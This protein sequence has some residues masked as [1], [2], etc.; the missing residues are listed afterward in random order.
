MASG[1]AS[2]FAFKLED[3]PVPIVLIFRTLL[4]R[5]LSDPRHAR[6]AASIKGSFSLASTTDPQ[7]ITISIDGK[8]VQLKHGISG[9]AKI[10]IHLDFNKISDTGY[11][12]KVDGLRKHPLFAYKVGRLLTFPASNWSDEAKNFWDMTHAIPRMPKAIKFISTDQSR[13]LTLGHGEPELE[14][15][16]T[17]SNLSSLLSGSSVLVSDLLGGKLQIR[18]SLEHMAILSEVT[19]NL[20]LGEI[21]HG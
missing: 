19:F 16:G 9:D 11:K 5:A 12:P 8:T 4:T 18:G 20:M 10:I 21:E 15:S 6:I 17:A 14:I 7:S 13:D 2:G 3:D 1:M